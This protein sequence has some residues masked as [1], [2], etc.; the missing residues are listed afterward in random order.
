MYPTR[1]SKFSSEYRPLLFLKKASW[2]VRAVKG[3]NPEGTG[4]GSS[5]KMIRRAASPCRLWPRERKIRRRVCLE[6][7]QEPVAECRSMEMQLIRKN[8]PSSPR[9]IFW[10]CSLPAGAVTEKRPSWAF[11]NSFEN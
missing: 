4:N 11:E 10:N 5:C 2:P 1:R 7:A 8:Q 3:G 6:E 9:V